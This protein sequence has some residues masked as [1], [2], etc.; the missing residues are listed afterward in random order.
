MTKWGNYFLENNFW[1]PIKRNSE[2]VI[3]ARKISAGLIVICSLIVLIVGS[4]YL[5]H[6]YKVKLVNNLISNGE[7]KKARAEFEDTKFWFLVPM[8]CKKKR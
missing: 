2:H 5:F 8:V 6:N 1:L 7:L 4:D 3:N